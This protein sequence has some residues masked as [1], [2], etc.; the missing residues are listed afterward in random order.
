[1][2]SVSVEN[3]NQLDTV[4]NIDSVDEIILCIDSFDEE[5]IINNFLMIKKQHKKPI[6]M[7]ES[8]T[9]DRF[10]TFG[11]YEILNNNLVDTVVVQ[12]INSLFYIVDNFK[13]NLNIILN[14][15]MNIYN[16]FAKSFFENELKKFNHKF[17]CPVELNINELTK[18]KYDIIIVY[19]YQPLMISKNCIYK[20]KNLCKKDKYDFIVDR[21]NNK[22]MFKSYC[23]FCYNK[24][25]NTYPT[26]LR[27]V[28]FKNLEIDNFRYDFTFEK[29]NEIKNVLLNNKVLDKRTKGHIIN[30]IK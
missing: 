23:K 5:E 2:I 29:E 25:F 7:L 30:S 27:D 13:S 20:N 11:H 26:D 22:F 9:R 6:L 28:E 10:N 19:G 4:L 8:I 17:V 18:I 15:N 14:Y 1:M 3:K 12:N 24:I 21:L 16:K